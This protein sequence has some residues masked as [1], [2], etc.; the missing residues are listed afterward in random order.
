[1]TRRDRGPA[2]NPAP[3]PRKGRSDHP[4][5]TP[6][7]PR[8]TV[9]GYTRVSSDGQAEHGGGLDAQRAAILGAGWNVN[10]WVS[11]PGYSGRTLKRPGMDGLLERLGP[12]DVL[13]AAKLDRLSRSMK[14]FCGL[15]AR[16]DDDG[17]SLVVLDVALD[18]S[19][20][21]GRF[22]AHLMAA[23]GE[24]ERGLISSRTKDGMA[25]KR[26]SG[27]MLGAKGYSKPGRPP[28]IPL[29]VRETIRGLREQGLSPGAIA[30][31][32]NESQTPTAGGGKAWWDSTVRRVLAQS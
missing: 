4:P 16:S 15:L 32:L 1:M 29:Q 21:Q 20:P 31:A 7:E 8:R 25:A 9:Y 12:G 5:A 26:A 23:V 19:T 13:V 11:D 28:S 10:E 2:M 18:T 14:D 22:V 6:A 27:T 3:S 17:W 24:L 30:R